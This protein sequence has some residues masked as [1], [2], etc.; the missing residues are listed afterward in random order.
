MEFKLIN[1]IFF[2]SIWFIAGVTIENYLEPKRLALICFGAVVSI[3]T[4]LF[5]PRI[6]GE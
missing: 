6:K 3:S 5:I 4:V 2:V 1:M